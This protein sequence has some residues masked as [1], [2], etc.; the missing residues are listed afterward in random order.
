MSR[1]KYTV[2]QNQTMYENES[3]KKTAGSKFHYQE[4]TNVLNV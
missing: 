1:G 3:E 2:G 4:N